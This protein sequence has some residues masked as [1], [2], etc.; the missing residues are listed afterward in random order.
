M[1]ETPGHDRIHCKAQLEKI[2][3][4]KAVG[5]KGTSHA[6]RSVSITS[7]LH[8]HVA[9]QDLRPNDACLP[10]VRRLATAASLAGGTY[11]LRRYAEALRTSSVHVDKGADA[12]T[13]EALKEA[14][15]RGWPRLLELDG[16]IA[17]MALGLRIPPL[18][19]GAGLHAELLQLKDGGTVR[20]TWSTAV[21]AASVRGLVLLLPGLGNTSNWAYLRLAMAHLA[22]RGLQGVCIDY[23]GYGGVPITSARIGSADSWRDLAEVLAH[24]QQRAPGLPLFGVGFSMG[25]LM[26]ANYLSAVARSGDGVMPRLTAAATISAPYDVS[27]HM[28]RLEAT[29]GARIVN[30][31]TVSL[32][33]LQFLAHLHEPSSRTHLAAVDSS[34]VPSGAVVVGGWV[35]GWAAAIL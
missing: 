18:R 8:V 17:T 7:D 2:D 29:V 6:G 11:L 21:G 33:K 26:L 16:W 23:R 35:G 19:K 9:Q 3:T 12:Q 1:R 4:R 20:L 28:A 5:R 24:M 27:A 31:A 30:A 32:A 34:R 25:G 10:M 13:L 22:T 15:Q 14:L